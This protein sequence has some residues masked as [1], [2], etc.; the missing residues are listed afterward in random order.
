MSRLRVRH[1]RRLLVGKALNMCG[2]LESTSIKKRQLDEQLQALEDNIY[3]RES[4]CSPDPSTQAT[5]TATW[6][7][8]APTLGDCETINL[9]L[10]DDSFVQLH[11]P[12]D[13]EKLLVKSIS[14][15]LL[16]QLLDLLRDCEAV[17][18]TLLCKSVDQKRTLVL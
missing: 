18:D 2:S 11:M 17:I 5:S 16:V 12:A 13:E 1:L 3:K 14:P 15:L 6:P 7:M 8:L 10:R 4:I 9:K